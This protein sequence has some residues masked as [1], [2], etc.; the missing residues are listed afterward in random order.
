M[1]TTLTSPARPAK[2]TTIEATVETPAA[3]VDPNVRV[4]DGRTIHRIPSFDR[5]S[6]ERFFVY[7][8]VVEQPPVVREA[9]IDPETGLPRLLTQH[10]PPVVV[11]E[12]GGSATAKFH[13]V[14]HV[15]DSAEFDARVPSAIH[16]EMDRLVA[17][18]FAETAALLADKLPPR[19]GIPGQVFDL[20]AVRASRRLGFDAATVRG[21][22]YRHAAGD[23]GTHGKLTDLS[24]EARFAPPVFGPLACSIVAIEEGAGLVV[25]RYVHKAPEFRSANDLTP[26]PGRFKEVA[27]DVA[28][29]LSPGGN[30]TL[31]WSERDQVYLP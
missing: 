24:D 30:H 19:P 5:A 18:G 22:L 12:A 28:T 4:I 6:G 21:F 8:E 3:P 16:D 25:S 10:K 1:S 23:F 31:V 11:W 9:G 17:S 7:R 29:L 14:S 20:G 26:V 13:A 15:V 27:I 2:A